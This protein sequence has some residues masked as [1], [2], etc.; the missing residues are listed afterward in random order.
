MSRCFAAGEEGG[1]A[2]EQEGEVAPPMTATSL[3]MDHVK[4]KN[5]YHDR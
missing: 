3:T 5:K 4:G 1:K 2:E